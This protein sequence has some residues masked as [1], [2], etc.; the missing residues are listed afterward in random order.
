MDCEEALQRLLVGNRRYAATRQLHPRQ[1]VTH[2][3]TLMESQNPF[4]AILSCS[5][6]RAPSEM[7]FDQ[8]LGDLFIIRTAGH[9]VNEL[10]L[11]SLEYAVFALQVPLLLVMGHSGCGAVASVMKG[12]P[13]PG[14][15]PQLMTILRPAIDS[16]DAGADDA[17]T[18]A[19]Y[20][21]SKYTAASIA[22]NSDIFAESL[23]LGKV[24]IVPAYYD[25]SSGRVN[26]LD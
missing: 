5:D 10:V 25:L 23:R 15:L 9:T 6:S 17:I 4:A 14:H 11:A 1:T 20:A 12:L 3:Q 7:I 19:T 22:R 21:N 2:R 13:L 18:Q 8:G 24:K 16:I 26:L